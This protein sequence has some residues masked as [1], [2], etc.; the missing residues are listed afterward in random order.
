LNGHFICTNKFEDF[1]AE[2]ASYVSEL[3]QA[4]IDIDKDNAR[5][6][7]EKFSHKQ[8]L[9][10]AYH[11]ADALWNQ[12]TQTISDV[13]EDVPSLTGPY[14]DNM[15]TYLKRAKD[16]MSIGQFLEDVTKNKERHE[17][18]LSQREAELASMMHSGD[19]E[20]ESDATVLNSK[21]DTETEIITRRNQLIIDTVS[22]FF[23]VKQRLMNDIDAFRNS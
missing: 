6:P 23:N 2:L 3:S 12:L 1:Y 16:A 17:S 10:T 9:R 8:S 13:L 4:C 14:D 22:Q 5:T 11:A 15:N 20:E 18:K 21:I 19:S 7:K